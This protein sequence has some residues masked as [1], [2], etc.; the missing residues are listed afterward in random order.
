MYD[1]YQDNSFTIY[2]HNVRTL[3]NVKLKDFINDPLYLKHDIIVI[4]EAKVLTIDNS[5]IS[6]FRVEFVSTSAK[7]DNY[8][9]FVC[10]SK[11]PISIIK[12][13]R[14]LMNKSIID[15]VLIKIKNTFI[16]TG[17]KSPM[18]GKKKFQNIVQ[19]MTNFIPPN[20]DII[21]I[22]D[23]NFDN[24]L[25]VN[26]TFFQNVIPNKQ[27]YSAF[28]PEYVTTIY[29]SQLDVIYANKSNIKANIYTT[30]NSDH[31]PVYVQIQGINQKKHLL[32]N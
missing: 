8:P 9:N 30:N 15:L 28:P 32:R 16:L 4:S 26:R 24:C 6:P 2:Y 23:F 12:S 10:L 17:Y 31:Y 7:S 14:E 13:Y 27:L 3:T 19:S 22:G 11:Q 18:L 5:V 20:Y 1:A 29:N 21:L 25:Q